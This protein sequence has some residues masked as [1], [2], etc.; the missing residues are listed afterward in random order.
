MTFEEAQKAM[1]CA[2]EDVNALRSMAG[3]ASG[4][5]EMADITSAWDEALAR[6][7]RACRNYA[8]AAAL[9]SASESAADERP[10]G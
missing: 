3:V 6:L 10:E 8:K 7:K 4:R 9:R 5:A 2:A 1:R